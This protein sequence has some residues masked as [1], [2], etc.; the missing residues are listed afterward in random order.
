MATYTLDLVDGTQLTVEAPAGITRNELF[1]LANE[2]M[3]SR[4]S[5][6]VQNRRDALARQE[7]ERRLAQ[8]E[9]QRRMEAAAAIP[10]ETGVFGDLRKGFGAGFI[11]TGELAATG[12]ATLLD[13]EAE[14]AARDKIQTIADAIK[15]EGGDKDDLSYKIGQTFGSIA[16]FAAPAALAVYAGAPA[17][18]GTGIA[19]LLGIGVGAGGQ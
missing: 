11:E 13:E 10:E 8:E 14:V 17:L 16:G 6:M 1:R 18:L 4:V 9:F 5:P 12:A 19:G 2:Q 3:E 15:P 7:E